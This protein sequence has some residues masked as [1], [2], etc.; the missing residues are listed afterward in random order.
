MILSALVMKPV[1]DSDIKYISTFLHHTDHTEHVAPPLRT[2][3]TLA[4]AVTYN[5]VT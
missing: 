2:V 1:G 4:K 5:V 3:T